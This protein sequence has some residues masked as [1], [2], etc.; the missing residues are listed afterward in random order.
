MHDVR[1][2]GEGLQPIKGNSGRNDI[3][4]VTING[5]SGPLQLRLPPF[6][7]EDEGAHRRPRGAEVEAEVPRKNLEPWSM[8][9]RGLPS[10]QLKPRPHRPS[11]SLKREEATHNGQ[12]KAEANCEATPPVH[13]PLS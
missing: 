7:R 3:P 4:N 13:G 11:P 10:N 12:E 9:N 1:Q 8:G 6:L 5:K 2:A